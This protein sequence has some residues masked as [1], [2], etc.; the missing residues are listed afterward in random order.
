MVGL[1][2]GS[3]TAPPEWPWLLPAAPQGMNFLCGLLLTYLPSEPEAYS[4]LALLMRQ[5]GLREM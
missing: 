1:P 4:A 2:P 3:L 5:R